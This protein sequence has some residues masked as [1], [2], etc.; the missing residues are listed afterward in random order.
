MIN[1]SED[2]NMKHTQDLLPDECIFRN[3]N[4]FVELIKT[5]KGFL[6]DHE[7]CVTCYE[8]VMLGLVLSKRIF[9]LGNRGLGNI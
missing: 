4:L 3:E 6:S 1:D 9:I 2:F 5:N 7:N 8:C